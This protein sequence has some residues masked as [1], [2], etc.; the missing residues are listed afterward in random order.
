MTWK[1]HLIGGCAA[2]AGSMLLYTHIT[3]SS[4]AIQ[5]SA[6]FIA[7]SGVS[8]LLPDV[9]EI[10][11]KA[12]RILLP[13]SL[14][15]FIMQAII[16]IMT[17]FTFG[18]TKQRIKENTSFLMHRG[19]C[20]YPITFFTITL[21]ACITIMV[22]ANSKEV[23]LIRIFA[24]TIGIVSHILLDIVSGKIALLFPL[25]KK[26]IGIKI[27]ESGSGLETFIVR[28]ALLVLC[29]ATIMKVMG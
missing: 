12:G 7:I 19:I 17:I 2:G 13:V 4:I 15:F 18:R 9:D 3:D 22:C 8:A 10:K 25:C 21:A 24:F 11:S 28:P 5:I 27:V 1:T 6:P 14:V 23:W 29:L 26:K 20:H 16:K